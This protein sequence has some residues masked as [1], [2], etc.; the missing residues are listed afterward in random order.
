VDLVLGICEALL[1]SR[2]LQIWGRGRV[3]DLCHDF[4]DRANVLNWSAVLLVLEN[5]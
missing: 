3:E 2:N 5:S 1:Q 4:A